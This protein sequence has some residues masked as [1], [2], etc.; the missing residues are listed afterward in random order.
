MSYDID[1]INQPE[2]P[3]PSAIEQALARIEA[4]PEWGIADTLPI[5][6]KQVEAAQSTSREERSV[7]SWNFTSNSS[8][9]W[10]EAGADLAEFDGKRARECL[11]LVV[12]AVQK[13]EADP[14]FYRTFDAA[15][16]WGT[17]KDLLPALRQLRD[18]MYAH[19][20]SVVSVSH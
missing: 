20:E 2:H 4:H 9:A 16:G 17:L 3:E 12:A 15:N 6:R 8:A 18:A 19:P 13:M 11:P 10:R 1:L 5:L 7:F 14:V